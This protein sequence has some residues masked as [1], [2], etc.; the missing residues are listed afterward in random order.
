MKPR[1]ILGIGW[2]GMI[3]YAFPGYMS[4]D[5]VA[6]LAEARLGWFHDAHPPAMAY[7]WEN[8]DRVVAGPLGML[9]LQVTCFLAGAYLILRERLTPRLAALLAVALL[10]FPPVANTMGVI[11]KDSQMAG[12]ALLGTALLLSPRLRVRVA[13]L[14][15][16]GLAT[17]MRYNAL[18][19]TF[20]IVVVLFVW[21]PAFRWWKR[22]GIALVAW[23]AIT[24]AARVVSTT[25]TD[26]HRFIW[27]QSLALLDI[28]GTLREAPDVPDAELRQ[29][30]AGTPLIATTDLS[31]RAKRTFHPDISP[32]ERLWEATD[33]FFERPDTQAERD[34]VARAW[35]TIVTSH[36]GAYLRYRTIVFGQLTQLD[37]TE[38]GSPIY[39][40]FGDIQDLDRSARQADHDA[41]PSGLQ[42]LLHPAMYWLGDTWMFH[43]SLYVVLALVLLPF[44]RGDRLVFALLTSGLLGELF[45]FLIA[46]TVDVRYSFWLMAVAVLSSILVVARRAARQ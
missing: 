31:A 30:L 22:Y 35:K 4:Y 14:G 12:Y 33:K 24:L 13:G 44:S 32:T 37:G 23:V 40:W 8:L 45:L 46:P 41:G 1:T 21:D 20:S 5:S 6:Q 28:V 27:H 9:L 39:F 38:L 3:L 19:M 18:A 43:V 26:Y 10:W 2:L 25:L 29:Q 15:L 16:L 42:S 34:A 7:L 36:L 11:W 17:A